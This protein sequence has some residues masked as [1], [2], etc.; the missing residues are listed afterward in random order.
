VGAAA[1]G[2]TGA[3][4]AGYVDQKWRP[5]VGQ[6]QNWSG[7]HGSPGPGSVIV[8]CAPQRWQ[9]IFTSRVAMRDSSTS[10]QPRPTV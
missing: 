4:G 8:I 2:W 3:A 6:T 1:A 10:R 5:H 7:R 9:A